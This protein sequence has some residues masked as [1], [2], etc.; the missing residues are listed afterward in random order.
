M[1]PAIPQSD[2]TPPA[3]GRFLVAMAT[4]VAIL[5]IAVTLIQFAGVFEAEGG[6]RWARTARPLFSLLVTAACVGVI[7][8]LSGLQAALA[9]IRATEQQRANSGAGDAPAPGR[10]RSSESAADKTLLAGL[11]PD[12][13]TA[14]AHWQEIVTLLRDIRDHSLLSEAQRAEKLARIADEDIGR[15][16]MRVSNLLEGNHFIQARQLVA[17]LARRFPN[18]PDVDQL[19]AKVEETRQRTE[20][21]DVAAFTKRI[22]EWIS[23]SAWDRAASAATELIERHPGNLDA[24]QLAER[25]DREHELFLG[26]QRQRLYA[27]I[28][29][30]CNRKRWREAFSGAKTFIERFPNC[31]DAETLRMQITTLQNN[32]EVEDRQTIDSEI[33]DLAK[34]GRYIE[35]Y[36]LALHLIQTYPGTPHADALKSQLPRL[37]ELAHNPNATPARVRIEG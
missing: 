29:R 11:S 5:G 32:A 9:R 7:V 10:S 19:A 13:A 1:Q 23:M 18:R 12:A 14:D 4:L 15:G 31:S 30:L 26:E 37:K 21:Q 2:P 16:M 36:N 24:K 22:E 34:H 8:G 33:T 6:F 35:A 17:E 27:E 28:Q 20:A 3:R 25:V